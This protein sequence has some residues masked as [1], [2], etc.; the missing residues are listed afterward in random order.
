ME[1]PDA[2]AGGRVVN[3]PVEDQHGRERSQPGDDRLGLQRKLELALRG[4]EQH[5]RECRDDRE[6]P[7]PA[8][9]RERLPARAA[10]VDVQACDRC[11]VRADSVPLEEEDEDE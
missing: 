11:D 9:V 2:R 8:A 1:A 4:H 6:Q 10:D 7:D 3:D 5:R